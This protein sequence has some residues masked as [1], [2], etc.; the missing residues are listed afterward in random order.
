MINVLPV[1]I[2]DPGHAGQLFEL[3][4][5]FDADDLRSK[6][7]SARTHS[8]VD[9]HRISSYL[10]VVRT[11][12]QGDGSTPVSISGDVPIPSVP[13]PS[14][15]SSIPDILGDPIHCRSTHQSGLLALR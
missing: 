15:K 12:P 5:R 2:L 7:R 11:C 6:S 3:L 10:F 8:H 14:T 13:Q 1:Q 9:L 4:D